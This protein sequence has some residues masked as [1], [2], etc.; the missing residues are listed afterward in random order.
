[1]IMEHLS[2]NREEKEL[3]EYGQ[4]MYFWSGFNPHDEYLEA[5]MGYESNLREVIAE[6]RGFS[7]PNLVA[8]MESHDEERMQ[9]KNEQFGNSAGDY[10]VTDEDTGLDR[11]KLASAFLPTKTAA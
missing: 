5:A 3:A 8:Y 2:E 7:G 11:I 4:G 10:N 6:N 9:F 1:M